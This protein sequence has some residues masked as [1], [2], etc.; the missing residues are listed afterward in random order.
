VAIA[1]V[2]V[3]ERAFDLGA[4]E[5]EARGLGDVHG[6]GVVRPRMSSLGVQGRILCRG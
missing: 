2:V 5:P 4:R 3:V 6:G 1:L